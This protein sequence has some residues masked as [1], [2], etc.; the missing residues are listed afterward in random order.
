MPGLNSLLYFT[1]NNP[2]DQSGICTT[3]VMIGV[4]LHSDC[5][6]QISNYSD[7]LGLIIKECI[8]ENDSA[9]SFRIVIKGLSQAIDEKNRTGYFKFYQHILSLLYYKCIN[10]TYTMDMPLT[11]IEI[12]SFDDCGWDP[13]SDTNFDK[14]Y[15]FSMIIKLKS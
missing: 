7:S 8:I 9:P 15:C 11:E 5:L 3:M 2:W 1:L 12:I 4:V 13:L 10:V 6:S 14:I